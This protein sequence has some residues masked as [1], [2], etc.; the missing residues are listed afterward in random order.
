[1]KNLCIINYISKIKTII[2]HIIL[3]YKLILI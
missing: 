2:C 3:D 1:M